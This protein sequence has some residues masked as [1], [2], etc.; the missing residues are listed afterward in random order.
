MQPCLFCGGDASEP[1]HRARCDGQQGVVE[2][3]LTFSAPEA[4]PDFDGA[5]YEPEHDHVRLGAQALR[6]WGVLSDGQWRTLAEIQAQ[7]GDP[8]ASISARLRDFRKSKFGGYAVERRRRGE[9]ARGLF[10]Y[11][12]PVMNGGSHGNH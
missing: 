2:A 10:E 6:V 4:A 5:T 12:V 3:G 11:R 8:Q 7:C 9:A 1:G